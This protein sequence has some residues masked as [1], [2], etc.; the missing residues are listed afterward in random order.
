MLFFFLLAPERALEASKRGLTLWFE[1]LLPTLLP[2]TV[3]SYLVLNAGILEVKKGADRAVNVP[4][5]FVILCGFLFGFPI[6]G[7]L[8]CDL[9]KKGL[10]TEKKAQILFA[11]TNNLS[12]VFVSSVFL[13]QL[14]RPA[15]LTDYA[16]LYGIPLSFGLCSLF[17]AGRPEPSVTA[18]HKKNAA[19]TR[20]L[21][22]QVVDAGIIN[23]FE[24]LIR[25]CGYIIMFSLAAELLTMLPF[26]SP[27]VKTF[28]IGTVEVTNGMSALSRLS[29]SPGLKYVLA[30]FFLSFGG[31]SGLFQAASVAGGTGLSAR[32]YLI[33]R[34]CFAASAV[35]LSL[36]LTVGRR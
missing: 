5:L 32:R 8:T 28:L 31:I 18:P 26:V 13:G 3:L 35:L 15:Q 17:L 1:Q 27:A 6:G 21:N 7:K 34:L 2:F 23:G 14:A 24:T 25:I 10:L 19:S 11:F 33:S 30:V 22:M 16:L 4:E 20:G 29:C 12:P 9:L 36:L